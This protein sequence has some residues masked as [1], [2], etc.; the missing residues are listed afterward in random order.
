MNR[1]LAALTAI[2]LLCGVCT[3]IGYQLGKASEIKK[4]IRTIENNVENHNE[5]VKEINETVRTVEKI[6]YRDREKIVRIPA[7]DASEPCPISE[8][9]R[10]RNE[11]YKALDSS[12]FERTD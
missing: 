3:M 8:L 12:L 4:E 7:V 1:L 9:T 6:I 11:S 10:V 5:D 2:V